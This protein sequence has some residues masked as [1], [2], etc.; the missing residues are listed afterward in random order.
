MPWQLAQR[1]VLAALVLVGLFLMHGLQGAAQH[2][3]AG[4]AALPHVVSASAEMAM[5]GEH[6]GMGDVDRPAAGGTLSDPG[7]M[8][9]LCLAVLLAGAILHT[10]L[11]RLRHS[12]GSPISA[13]RTSPVT[14]DW[15]RLRP[16]RSHS[17]RLSILCVSRT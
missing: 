8:L 1:L 13:S 14:F 6:G 15:Q 2:Q 10:G 16:P 3:H 7:S 5:G 11:R 17:R 9:G 4:D 12:S